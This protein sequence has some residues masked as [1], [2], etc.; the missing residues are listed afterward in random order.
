VSTQNGVTLEKVKKMIISISLIFSLALVIEAFNLWVIEWWEFQ[1]SLALGKTLLIWIILGTIIG[2]LNVWEKE[3]AIGPI[4]AIWGVFIET[5]N[6][7]FLNLWT[8]PSKLTMAGTYIVWILL[9]LLV[10]LNQEMKI[11]EKILEIKS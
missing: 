4:I 1:S 8:F 6:I 2:S 5:I 11:S 9:G 10:Y 7:Y 3:K